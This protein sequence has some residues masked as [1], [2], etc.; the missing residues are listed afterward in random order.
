MLTLYTYIH[1]QKNIIELTVEDPAPT[2]TALRD[3]IDFELF[4]YCYSNSNNDN[5]NHTNATTARSNNKNNNNN[6]SQTNN[7]ITK[8]NN[9]TTPRI[10]S[11]RKDDVSGTWTIY[12]YYD[13]LRN[14]GRYKTHEMAETAFE[15]LKSK[16][17][18]LTPQQYNDSKSI[19]DIM[20]YVRNTV[21]GGSAS[22]TFSNKRINTKDKND[23]IP[24]KMSIFTSIFSSFP[25]SSSC[26]NKKSS[27][28]EFNNNNKNHDN[29]TINNINDCTILSDKDAIKYSSILKIT[30]KQFHRIYE[31]YKIV[32]LHHALTTKTKKK[33]TAKEK[34]DLMKKY[35]LFIKKRLNKLYREDLDEWKD[36]IKA[37]KEQLA[38]MFDEVFKYYC[39]I[40]KIE[41]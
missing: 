37:R 9:E 26:I 5:D 18:S 12:F 28:I 29:S 38:L 25:L 41:F 2:C 32:L 39:A 3:Y 11:F 15:L 21:R 8:S 23:T 22:A 30:P 31:L 35:R 10:T 7:T 27:M 16:V 1:E 4:K 36:D 24:T 40:C 13:K 6:K 20:Q 34:D 14:L 19:D 33:K 17:A